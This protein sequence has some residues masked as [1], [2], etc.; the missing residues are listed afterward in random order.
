M[1]AAV[2]GIAISKAALQSQLSKSARF[3][4]FCGNVNEAAALARIKLDGLDLPLDEHGNVKESHT[5]E[6]L[7]ALRPFAIIWQ[8]ERQGYALQAIGTPTA[9]VESGTLQIRL[10]KAIDPALVKTTDALNRQWDNDLGQIARELMDLKTTA[11][12]LQIDGQVVV[13][14]PEFGVEAL[15]V[16]QGYF[17]VAIL[18]VS[19][20]Q[21]GSR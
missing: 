8:R 17:G 6:E 4:A 21:G 18:T 10:E 12:M 5:A 16:G 20:G 3:Q 11:G 7:R 2:A 19:W 14:G 15:E 1:D 13:D 9:C